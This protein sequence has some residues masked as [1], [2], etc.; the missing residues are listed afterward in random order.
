MNIYTNKKIIESHL[1]VDKILDESWADTAV[2]AVS[3]GYAMSGDARRAWAWAQRKLKERKEKKR[4][5]LMAKKFIKDKKAELKQ[6]E[7]TT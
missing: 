1:L 4:R 6:K 2:N 7:K 3:T 5:E